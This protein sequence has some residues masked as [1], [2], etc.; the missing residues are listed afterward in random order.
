MLRGDYGHIQPPSVSW[1]GF[2]AGSS[3]AW[4]SAPSK[5]SVSTNS[6]LYIA[7][8]A[9]HWY[10]EREQEAGGTF[11]GQNSFD[12]ILH[13]NE[14]I[15]NNFHVLQMAKIAYELGN[16]Y[17]L[18]PQLSNVSLLWVILAIPEPLH[19]NH[20]IEFAAT[21]FVGFYYNSDYLFGCL[22]WIFNMVASAFLSHRRLDSVLQKVTTLRNQMDS[23]ENLT[24]S[25]SEILDEIRF[26]ADLEKVAASM[27]LA[28][29]KS[30]FHR[31]L[32][33]VSRDEKIR[34]SLEIS[35]IIDLQKTIWPRSS[36]TGGGFTDSLR[37][38][39]RLLDYLDTN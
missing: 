29:A 26:T 18:L 2:A 13:A 28:R 15:S 5:S 31:S 19:N 39:R 37:K 10:E 22:G 27:W 14:K 8:L 34:L 7:M 32:E 36:K 21:H 4:R 12:E 16:V 35:N 1:L 23:I 38:L 6:D 17:K 11:W 33:S 3:C 30:G 24:Q 25:Q 20:L 9:L